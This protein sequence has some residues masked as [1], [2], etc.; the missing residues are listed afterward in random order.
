MVQFLIPLLATQVQYQP[1]PV[2]SVKFPATMTIPLIA[3]KRQSPLIEV[4]VKGKRLRFRVDSGAGGSHI[5][6]ATVTKLGLKPVRQA[7]ISDPSGKELQNI[8]EYDIPVMKIGGATVKGVTATE[9]PSMGDEDGIL[10]YLVFKDMLLSMN[11]KS[12]S[13]TISKGSLPVTASRYE[14]SNDLP[15]VDLSI[16]PTKMKA[17]LD[18]GSDGGIYV[19]D[20]YKSK[21]NFSGPLTKIGQ[22]RTVSATYD[23]YAG[24]TTDKVEIG[25]R[26]VKVSI[27]ET[28]KMFP[29]AT[30]GMRVFGRGKLVLDLKNRRFDLSI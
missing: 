15:S 25:G 20:Q 17:F 23:V 30:I 2:R 21:I 28:G 7:N 4:M 8:S 19:P 11:F 1:L 5:T 27:L 3:S 13:F 10:S 16:G 29:M 26:A 12:K 14:L 24:R 9:I 18:C 6:R 22:A